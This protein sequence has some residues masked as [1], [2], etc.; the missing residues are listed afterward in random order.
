MTYSVW[1]Q[2]VEIPELRSPE[3]FSEMLHT[4]KKDWRG[5]SNNIVGLSFFIIDSFDIAFK[6][7]LKIE[8]GTIYCSANMNNISTYEMWK[9][10]ILNI[11]PPVC[12]S[13]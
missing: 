11:P 9:H 7:C 8:M 3:L 6:Y 10:S 12:E 4:R 5:V 13:L 2:R 1:W